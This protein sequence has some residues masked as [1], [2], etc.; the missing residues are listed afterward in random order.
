[1]ALSLFMIYFSVYPLAMCIRATNPYEERAMGLVGDMDSYIWSEE[2]YRLKRQKGYV[3]QYLR[4]QL[5]YDIWWI[6][7]VIFFVCII[8]RFNLEN[9]NKYS[10]FTVF[11]IIFEITSAYANCGLSLGLP[12]IGTS[13][14]GSWHVLSKLLIMAVM[15]RG[16]TR[17]LPF[18]VDYAILITPES[19]AEHLKAPA[20]DTDMESPR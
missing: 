15:I 2:A 10:Y 5:A 14:S 8:E 1:M 13:F 3:E 20:G 12:Y 11:A 7:L 18:L 4:D 19:I 6:M 16:R 9:P 17:G